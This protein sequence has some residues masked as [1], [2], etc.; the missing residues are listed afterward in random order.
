MFRESRAFIKVSII[1]SCCSIII[2]RG[3]I[4]LVLVAL[5]V[6]FVLRRERKLQV[7]A[8]TERLACRQG[9]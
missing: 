6:P 4:Q 7:A 9:S 3:G 5:K 8:L 1:L 2:Q